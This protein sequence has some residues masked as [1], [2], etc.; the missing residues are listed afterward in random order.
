[1]QDNEALTIDGRTG[2]PDPTPPV[3]HLKTADDVRLEMARVY[4]D[5]R[6]GKI[7]TADGTKFAYVLGQL[8]KMIETGQLEAR[9]EL[10]EH[11]LKVRKIK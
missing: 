7:E 4:R 11:T 9:L 2:K 10:I 6:Q 1:M 5:M 8:A 3:I